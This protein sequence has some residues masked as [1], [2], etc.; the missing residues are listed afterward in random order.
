MVLEGRGQDAAA[1]RQYKQA[2]SIAEKLP[3]SAM[4]SYT[5]HNY[6]SLLRKLKREVEAKRVESRAKG[7]EK[8]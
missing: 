7:L 8:Q 6:S 4:L 3:D 2:I 1:E 5:L